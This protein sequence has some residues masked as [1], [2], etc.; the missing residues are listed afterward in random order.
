MAGFTPLGAFGCLGAVLTW[1]VRLPPGALPQLVAD[2]LGRVAGQQASQLL[3]QLR[4]LVR[5][6]TL[7]CRGL[8]LISASAVA[9][10]VLSAAA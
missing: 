9:C 10:W 8:L 4:G 5:L 1:R 6:N 7:A 2:L 3:I